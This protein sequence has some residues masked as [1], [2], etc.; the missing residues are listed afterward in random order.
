MSW[1]NARSG[2]NRRC[3][4][5]RKGRNSKWGWVNDRLALQDLM[6]RFYL[7]RFRT[8]TERRRQILFGG[9]ADYYYTT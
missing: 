9:L 7:K 1:S 4:L 5:R 3:S 2:K 8:G 6:G